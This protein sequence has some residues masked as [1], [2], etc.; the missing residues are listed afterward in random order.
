MFILG[1][2]KGAFLSWPGHCEHAARNLRRDM[3][4]P[5]GAQWKSMKFFS[6]FWKFV[7]PLD[8]EIRRSEE[9]KWHKCENIRS[10][11]YARSKGNHSLNGVLFTI[12]IHSTCAHTELRLLIYGIA[13]K[14]F[15]ISDIIH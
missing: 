12:L 9:F 13:K 4:T 8:D 6:R 2:I 11:V 5:V 1:Q 7:K 15:R 14:K 3:P 10:Y